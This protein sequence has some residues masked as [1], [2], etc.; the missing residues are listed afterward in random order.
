MR[1]RNQDKRADGRGAGCQKHLFG[2]DRTAR[3]GQPM[4]LAVQP[5]DA[6]HRA[7]IMQ[8]RAMPGGGGGEAVDIFAHVHLG[9]TWENQPAEIAVGADFRRHVGARDQP[10]LRIGTLDHQGMRARQLVVVRGLRRHL[11]LADALEVA[12][13]AFL[14]DQSLDCIDR[15]VEALIEPQA[16]FRA[17]LADHAGIILGEAVVAHSAVATRC[18]AAKPVSFEQDDAGTLTREGDGGR[19]AGKTATDHRHVIVA[20]QG[21]LDGA[22]KVGGSVLPI[23]DELHRICL[24]RRIDWPERTSAPVRKSGGVAPG[25]WW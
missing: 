18:T 6:G 1:R 3:R 22:K 4:G 2:S 15:R 13:D 24:N 20:F 7:V 5:L 9:G 8:P 25:S 10:G 23:G 19:Q 21:P 11:Q 12:V 16:G 14:T 17:Q